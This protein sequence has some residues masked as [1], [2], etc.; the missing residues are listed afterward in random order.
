MADELFETLM[1]NVAAGDNVAIVENCRQA[2]ASGIAAREI[3]TRGLARGMRKI[4]RD[5]VK[6]GMYLDTILGATFAFSA[7]VEA[8][9]DELAKERGVPEGTV[10]LGVMD[11]PWTIGPGIVASVLEANNFKAIHAGSDIPPAQLAVK[12][13]EA[14]A[15]VVAVGSYLSY[16]L[17]MVE[18]LGERLAQAG[19]RHKIRLILSGPAANERI[20][21]QYG[22]DSYARDAEEIAAQCHQFMATKKTEMTSRQRVMTALKLQAPD[23][24]PLVPFS[25][26]FSAKH[27]GIKFSDYC[28]QGE[29]LAEAEIKACHRFGWDSVIA[30]SDMAIYAESLGAEVHLP[31]D[32]IPRITR[33]AIRVDH[34]REDFER[35][36]KI[37]PAEYV[38]R[39]RLAEMI[40]SVKYMREEVRDEVAIIGWIEGAFQGTMLLF[41]ADPRA[42]LLLKE[43][44]CLMFEIF[45]WYNEFAF[46]AAKEMIDLGAD[47]IGSGASA[48]YYLSPYAFEMAAFVYEQELYKRI[49]D[50]G[51]PVLIHCCGYVPQCIKFAPE[52]NP[53]GAI[54]FDYQVNLK[55]AKQL[56]GDKMTIMGNLDCNRVLH[57]GSKDDVMEACRR[58]IRDAAPGGGF[59]LSGGCEIPRD[60]PYE[61]MD[62][63][64]KAIKEYGRYP[65]VAEEETE[66]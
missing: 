66:T 39:G 42:L 18:D 44:A 51:A 45:R 49:T 26:T 58:A 7:G 48:T 37:P 35:I 17:N 19:L 62:A 41:G 6:E 11:G 56:I 9:K 54:Q 24:V 57:L 13:V 25:M 3:V 31:E 61:N 22:A 32:D 21:R 12:A 23:R 55:W 52:V 14:R 40:Q 10:V 50:Y 16:K 43:D 47:V 27:A 8:I 29:A 53:R 15:D 59:W 36:K 20:A 65:I 38:K 2:L 1:K 34:A 4:A 63:M 46:A 30:S 5:L 28:S 33:P 64:L 60:M